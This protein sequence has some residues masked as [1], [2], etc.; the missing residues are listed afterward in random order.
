[1]ALTVLPIQAQQEGER[2]AWGRTRTI[3]DCAPRLVDRRELVEDRF[4]HSYITNNPRD[5]EVGYFS[6]E[7]ITFTEQ[8][9]RFCEAKLPA[10][11][12]SD[13]YFKGTYSSSYDLPGD[14]TY[15][16]IFISQALIFNNEPVLI[17]AQNGVG[18][19]NTSHRMAIELDTS[20][21]PLSPGLPLQL[22]NDAYNWEIELS[23]DGSWKGALSPNGIEV[24]DAE[25]PAGNSVLLLK[26][27]VRGPGTITIRESVVFRVSAL[28]S[29]KYDPLF[30]APCLFSFE[31]LQ[32]SA[33]ILPCE[34]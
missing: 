27:R 20:L 8:G 32:V 15:V 22:N 7:P 1:M 10:G 12:V 26:R 2:E 9:R 33:R 28:S 16:L 24:L 5:I 18:E 11:G 23:E 4:D 31:P 3:M 25:I 13:S 19:I 17:N 14:R 21:N 30:Q 34:D 29:F 6:V